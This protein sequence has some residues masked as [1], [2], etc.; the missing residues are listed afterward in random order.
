MNKTKDKGDIGVAAV[1][2]D[3]VC[4]GIKIALPIS[5]HLPF[6]LIAIAP[7]AQLCRLSVKYRKAVNSLVEATT[8]SVY[9]NRKGCHRIIADKAR[10]DAIALY[11]PDIEKVAYVLTSELK[12]AKRIYLRTALP[13]SAKAKQQASKMHMFEDFTDPSRLWRKAADS[14]RTPGRA[15]SV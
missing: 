3:L 7:D 8:V 11:C 13:T 9:S 4:A 2:S 12:S 10:L 6:D 14:H 1:I 5:D 15:R